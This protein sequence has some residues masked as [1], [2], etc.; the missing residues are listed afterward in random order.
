MKPS[1]NLYKNIHQWLSKKYGKADC[2][3]WNNCKWSSTLY[4]YA[5]KSDKEY[6][7]NRDNF[8]MLC[9]SCHRKYDWDNWLQEPQRKIFR[10]S[11]VINWKNNGKVMCKFNMENV[12]RIKELYNNWFRQRFIANLY[13]ADQSTISLI[14]NNRTY[15]S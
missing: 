9:R 13:N 5:L 1:D 14:V 11:W 10:E 6:D 4:E 7:K 15:A 3:Q 2:C 12:G 8:I